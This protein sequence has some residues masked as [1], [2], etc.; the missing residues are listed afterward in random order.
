MGKNPVLW[1]DGLKEKSCE[2]AAAS[3]TEKKKRK[4]NS[5][6]TIYATS[7]YHLRKTLSELLKASYKTI[8][9]CLI[10]LRQGVRHPLALTN[11]MNQLNNNKNKFLD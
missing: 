11:N 10:S 7:N 9:V 2:T 5:C 1:C 4:G 8:F 3:V 6:V